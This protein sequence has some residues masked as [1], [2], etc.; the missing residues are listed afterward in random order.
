MGAEPTTIDQR[1]VK[2]I[3]HP[4]RMRILTLLNQKTASPVELADELGE[5]L[6]NVSYHVRILLDLES[7]EL[8]DTVPRRGALEHY[9][10]ALKRPWFKAADWQQLPASARRSVSDAVLAQVWKEVTE[11]TKHGLFDARTDRHLSRTTLVLD[12]RGWQEVAELLNDTLERVLQI[13]ADAATRL[14][15]QDSDEESSSSAIVLMHYETPGK[16]PR[17]R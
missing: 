4:T 8:V 10:R 11:A 15:D 3:A 6:G 7:I 5:P 12:D 13:Q 9:Y 17:K 14:A 1:M 2:S 16:A